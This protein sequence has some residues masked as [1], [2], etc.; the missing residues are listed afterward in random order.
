[1]RISATTLE[2]FR[3]WEE[4]DNEWMTE[5]SLLDAILNKFVPTP[6]VLLGKAFGEV[7]ET[8][9]RYQVRGGFQHGVYQFG[10]DVMDPCLQLMDRQGVYEAKATKQYGDCTVVAKA[11][12]IIGA[13][14]IE[15]KTTLSTF[16]FDKY[17]HSCQWRFMADI[18]QPLSITYHVFC[19]YESPNGVIEL[20]GIESFNLFPYAELHEDC[21]ELVRRFASYVR[22]KGLDGVL[23]E[24]QKTAEAA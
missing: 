12:Q 21:H 10:H 16:D 8:P 11:D 24:R 17:A 15:H 5:Q 7:L 19:L 4:P 3:L 9:E 6:A 1:M 13:R 14:L 20:R 2:S 18:F 22:A 23:R